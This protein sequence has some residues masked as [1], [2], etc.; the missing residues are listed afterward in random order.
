MA[1]FLDAHT[2]DGGVSASDVAGAH[3]ADLEGPA[4]SLDSPA[5]QGLVAELG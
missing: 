3:R 4:A 5:L 2:I 1:L